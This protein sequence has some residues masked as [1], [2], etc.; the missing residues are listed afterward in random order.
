MVFWRTYEHDLVSHGLQQSQRLYRH[1]TKTLFYTKTTEQYL[2]YK[3]SLFSY[4]K[5]PF[6]SILARIDFMWVTFNRRSLNKKQIRRT[7][8][9]WLYSQIS[10]RREII[11]IVEF[12]I[13]N[14]CVFCLMLLLVSTHQTQMHKAVAKTF[15]IITN[16]F[17]LWP[18]YIITALRLIN[19]TILVNFFTFMIAFPSLLNPIF[20]F[21]IKPSVLFVMTLIAKYN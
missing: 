16:S 7:C 10:N 15:K 14:Q 19:Y 9:K 17:T 3:E 2:L 21:T 20:A 11:T 4:S 12:A 6:F 13:T 18:P 8:Q 1:I 5:L